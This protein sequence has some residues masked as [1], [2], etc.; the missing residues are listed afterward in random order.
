[1]SK[2]VLKYTSVL[3][4]IYVIYMHVAFKND[5]F[6]LG[7]SQYSMFFCTIREHL[8]ASFDLSVN[9]KVNCTGYKS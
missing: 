5:I 4:I 3:N 7:C 2:G 6:V 9:L 8:T 1:M